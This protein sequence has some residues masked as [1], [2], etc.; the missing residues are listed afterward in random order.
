[1]TLQAK[2]THSQLNLSFVKSR[3]TDIKFIIIIF[4]F[5]LKL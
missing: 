4:L 1:M 5:H 2:Q 3:S